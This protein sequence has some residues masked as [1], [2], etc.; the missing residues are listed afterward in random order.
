[1]S[2]NYEVTVTWSK[3]VLVLDADGADHA[4]SLALD[5][6]GVDDDGAFEVAVS[7]L[8]TPEQETAT[9]LVADA[10]SAP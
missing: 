2:T 7:E 1:M 9:R 5:Q 4:R 8:T 10:I 6:L 3:V